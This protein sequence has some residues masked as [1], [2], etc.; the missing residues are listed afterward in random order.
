MFFQQRFFFLFVIVDENFSRSTSKF[1]SANCKIEVHSVEEKFF[2]IACLHLS[3]FV[4]LALPRCYGCIWYMHKKPVLSGYDTFI[5]RIVKRGLCDNYSET[6]NLIGQ[7]PCRMRQSF[8]GNLR[9]GMAGQI[10]QTVMGLKS[11]KKKTFKLLKL[12]ENED[13]IKY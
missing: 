8:P 3:I 11:P 1:S 12:A 2:F 6:R 9:V 4:F 7:C 5:R 10:Y 13:K